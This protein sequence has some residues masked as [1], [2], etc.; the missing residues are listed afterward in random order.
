[1]GEASD[2][3]DQEDDEQEE[4]SSEEATP[5][6]PGTEATTSQSQQADESRYPARER[7]QPKEWYKIHANTAHATEHDEPQTHEEALRS[8]NASQWRLAMDEE[9]A[10]LQA[11]NNNNN[12]L[13]A[14]QLIVFARYL[15]G[16]PKP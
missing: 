14:F 8:P 12:N 10:S 6:E 3:S 11:N 16:V 15:L 2:V 1:M 7:R 13:Q 5:A 9:I 4:A